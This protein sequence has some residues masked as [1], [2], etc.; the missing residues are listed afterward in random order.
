ML[1]RI[2]PILL[3][4]VLA[5]VLAACGGSPTLAILPAT[6]DFG[7]IAEDAPVTAT[8]QVANTGRGKLIISGITTSCGCTTAKVDEAELTPGAVTNLT[9]TFDPQAHPGL[10]GPLLRMV[11]LHSND[12][13]QPEVEV[14]V[15]V[16][17][18]D[19]NKES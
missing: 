19:P 1:I 11:Y 6:Y 17:I 5:F 15:T 18:L 8:L 13:A 14:P 3:L 12:P 2:R 9:I 10:Y 7:A 16:D 4:V